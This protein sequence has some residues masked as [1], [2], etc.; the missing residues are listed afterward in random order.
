MFSVIIFNQP[1][2]VLSIFFLNHLR[3]EASRISTD[4]SFHNFRAE[5]LKPFY[6]RS[7]FSHENSV[8]GFEDH[9]NS[10]FHILSALILAQIYPKD[11]QGLSYS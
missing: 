11:F 8:L 5:Y 9:E 7:V 6:A 4:A 3:A 2:D 1:I 10:L